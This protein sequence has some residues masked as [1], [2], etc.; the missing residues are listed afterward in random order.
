MRRLVVL[1]LVL[2]GCGSEVAPLDD[3]TAGGRDGGPRPD[4]APK[5]C[6][7]NADC[8]AAVCLKGQCCPTDR[9]CGNQCCGGDAICFANACVKPGKSCYYQ[10]DCEPGQYCEPG[11]GPQPPKPKLDAGAAA[12]AAKPRDGGKPAADGGRRCFTPP[13][14]S[15]KCVPLPPKCPASDAGAPPPPAGDAGPS[16][17]PACEFR[18]AKGPLEAVVKWQWGPT[19]AEH[20]SFTDVWSTPAVARLV[21][22]NCDGKVNELDPPNVIFVSGDAKGTCCSCGGY[23]PST[24]LTG[25]LRVLDGASGKELWSLRKAEASSIGFAGLSLAVGDLDGDGRLEIAAVTGERHLVVVSGEGKVLRKSDK[26]IP[27]NAA[28]FGWGGALAIADMDGDGA[29]EIAYG[30]T[31][32]GTAGGGL[33]LKWTGAKGIGGG[34]A[35]Q[36][37]SIFADLDG[38]ADGRLELLAGRTAYRADGSELWHRADLPDGFPAVGDFDADGKPEAVLVADGQLWVLRGSSGETLAGPLAL[39]G[40]GTGGAPTVADFDRDGR[41]EIGVAMQNFYSVVK[42]DLAKKQ[43]ALLWKTP[44]HDLS[45]SV[46]GSTVFDFEG[47]GEAEVIY[48]DEC[49]LWVYEG[50]TGAVR[51][52]TPHTSFTAT[53][54]SLVADVDGDGHAEMLMVSNGANPGPGG[55]GCDVAPWN[56][57]D[58]KSGRP[59]W[60]KPPYGP[61][62]RGLV[63]F[64]DRASS[65]VATRTLWNQHSYHVTNIC[66]PRDGACDK[67]SSYGAIPKREKRNWTLPWLNNF[68]QNVQDKGLFDAP[69]ATVTLAV[70]CKTPPVLH[71]WVRNMGLALLPAGVEVGFYVKQ[72]A[73][74]KLLGKGKTSLA[75]L[76]GQ[77]EDVAYKA[78][79]GDGVSTKD[80]FVARLLID[81]KSAPFRECR[82]NNNDSD[83]TK[84]NCLLE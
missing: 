9:V 6:V 10:S 24:C 54:A 65:W 63:L 28:S 57:P 8:N 72:G 40:G 26:P 42:P 59:A 81:P 75:L 39:A 13:P 21:D 34:G 43:L 30:A 3:A 71:A 70:E 50:K 52:A 2:A 16:C 56:Q 61:A 68:R 22:T 19:A 44:N 58:P 45:S 84:G 80:A 53:E 12:D 37:I 77:A 82:A 36:A 4:A 41:R 5:G 49:F 7:I 55:W 35:A 29:P 74:E 32:F 51:F 31:V 20:P 38:A 27:H 73:G 78:L 1:V 60:T 48:N 25:V 18:P 17:Y 14:R 64:G 47:D 46:T 69:D 67:P 62:Y 33:A 11:L 83:V 76:A 23:A 66:D 15:G 79:P